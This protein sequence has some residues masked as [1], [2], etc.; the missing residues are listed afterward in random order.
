M[1]E[2]FLLIMSDNF[3]RK[4][5]KGLQSTKIIQLLN[6]STQ[7]DNTNLSQP[8]AKQCLILFSLWCKVCIKTLKQNMV[9]SK[10]LNNFLPIYFFN[11]TCSPLYEEF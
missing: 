9:R 3:N 4:V 8:I 11:I 5:C 10:C 7:L 1:S 6:L 2:L